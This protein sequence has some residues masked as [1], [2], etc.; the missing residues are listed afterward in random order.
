MIRLMF[1]LLLIG[2]ILLCGSACGQEKQEKEEQKRKQESIN[3]WAVLVCTSRWW[4]NYRHVAN[5]LSFYRTVKR[6]GVPDSQIILMLA[7]DMACNARN[8]EAGAIFNN[9]DHKLNVYGSDVQVDYR[10]Y[11]VSVENLIRLLT[12]R[13]RVNVPLSKRLMTDEHSNVLVYM[14]GHGGEDFIKFQDAEEINSHDLGDAFAQMHQMRRYRQILFMVD[15]CQAATLYSHFYSPE[16]LAIGSSMLGEN[17]YSHHMDR[18]VGV[19]VVD[20]F[21]YYA[22]EYLER[23]NLSSANTMQHFFDSFKS[24]NVASTVHYRT[25]LFSTPLDRLRVTDFFGAT[26]S[27]QLDD[28]TGDNDLLQQLSFA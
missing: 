26:K 15:T 21:T 12:G 27:L 14:T 20:R 1:L 19:A 8:K 9:R 28:N 5:T 4:Y 2:C 22:L 6:L 16:I 10:G 24:K 23:V 11:E 17:S 18:D 3:N 7:D 13:H 25:D